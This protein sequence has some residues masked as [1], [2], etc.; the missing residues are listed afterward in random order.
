[1]EGSTEVVEMRIYSR[2]RIIVAVI[3][4]CGVFGCQEEIPQNYNAAME[5]KTQNSAATYDTNSLSHPDPTWTEGF[6][7]KEGPAIPMLQVGMVDVGQGDCLIIGTPGKKIYLV[8]GGPPE[9]AKKVLDL[10]RRSGVE[11]VDAVFVTN[12]NPDHVGGLPQILAG[13]TFGQIYGPAFTTDTEAEKAVRVAAERKGKHLIPMQA[14]DVIP[15]DTKVRL[16]VVAP[17]QQ[18]NRGS[19]DIAGWINA[20][21]VVMG[22]QFGASRVLLASN[23]NAEER[24]TLLASGA[25]LSASVVMLAEH[26]SKQGTDAEF[27]A[28]VSPG[29]TLISCGEGNPAGT[30]HA[31]VMS[32]LKQMLAHVSRTDLQ[33]SVMVRC[34][35]DGHISATPSRGGTNASLFERGKSPDEK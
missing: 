8:D 27:L 24:D 25:T 21:S 10:C 23:M 28:R 33:G 32:L 16:E 3:A 12:W 26:G 11:R 4:V 34:E 35:E 17:L 22:L 5:H 15:L 9:A 18:T 1:L 13:I 30:P 20:N 14:G 6:I 2:W 7:H 31:E 19:Q 29:L